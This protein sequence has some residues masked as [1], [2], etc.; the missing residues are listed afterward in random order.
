MGRGP[1]ALPKVERN[2]VKTVPYKM[3]SAGEVIVRPGNEIQ[4]WAEGVWVSS[5]FAPC[6]ELVQEVGLLYTS[7][8]AEGL[9][10]ASDLGNHNLNP[11][12]YGKMDSCD[13]LKSITKMKQGPRWIIII[14]SL[15]APNRHGPKASCS[16]EIP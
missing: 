14:F 16:S 4:G 8:R 5:P 7:R 13:I 10:W 15:S 6:K 3:Q 9:F 2:A 12:L 1:R 11:H